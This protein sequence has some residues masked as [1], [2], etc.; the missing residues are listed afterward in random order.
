VNR[1]SARRYLTATTMGE[2]V[3]PLLVLTLLY[4]FDEFD[5]AAFNTLAP[6]I[7]KAFAI[8]T[9]TFTGLVIL[10]VSLV[11]L[12]AIPL[13]YVAD[14]VRRG[15]IVVICALLAGG[16]SFATGLAPTI[17]LLTLF[18]VGNGIGVTAN[19]TVHNSMLADYYTPGTRPRAFAL[20]TNALYLGAIVGPLL[21][22]TIG[23]L[24]GW[25]AAFF[26][27]FIPV[28]VTTVFAAR[29]QEPVRGGT[30]NPDAAITAP[31]QRVGF[32]Q[33]CRDLMNVPTLKYQY[34]G[35]VFFGA[36]LIP[37]AVYLPL[38]LQNVFGVGVFWRGIIGGAQAGV[39]FIALQKGGKWTVGWFA[40]DMGE[41]VRKAAY[42]L[43]AVGVGLAV[44]SAA[45]WLW[46]Y[47]VL[48]LIT[49]ALV[50]LLFSP[51]YST[52]ALVSPARVRTLS[53]SLGSVFLVVGVAVFYGVGLGRIANSSLRW[54]VISLAPWWIIAACFLYYSGKFVAGDTAKA[55]AALSAPEPINPA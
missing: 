36:G 37:L 53:F 2:A 29:L 24:A 15:P 54:G 12:L 4:F 22:G 30:D 7:K 42:F 27:L 38:V 50:G 1:P 26:V 47:L 9:N 3:F 8:N 52:L 32:W 44:T 35:T 5:T 16:F 11:I 10:N 39:T 55:F 31:Q 28:M 41:P 40:K 19:G 51:Y 43:A 23:Y 45:P 25:R 46:L 6:E 14:R 34:I 49:N 48:S 20:H 21:A 33:G 18:R 13:G 17:A